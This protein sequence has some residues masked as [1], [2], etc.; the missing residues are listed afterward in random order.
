MPTLDGSN[1]LVA[2]IRVNLAGELLVTEAQHHDISGDDVQQL[3]VSH[4]F[5]VLRTNRKPLNHCIPHRRRFIVNDLAEL[6]GG[7]GFLV[8]AKGILKQRT[9][10]PG[11]KEGA[12]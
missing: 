4:P 8:F 2:D 9:Q 10:Q 12:A 11:A 3:R 6:A 5:Q 1:G 7:G